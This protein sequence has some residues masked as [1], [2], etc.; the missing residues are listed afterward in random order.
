MAMK[1]LSFVLACL[2]CLSMTAGCE[3]GDKNVREPLEKVKGEDGVPEWVGNPPK[4]CAKGSAES[5]GSMELAAVSAQTRAKKGLASWMETHID[6]MV[7]DFLSG[8]KAEGKTFVDEKTTQSIREVV[9]KTMFGTRM[10]RE[11]E[12]GKRVFS[13]VCLDAES[14][15][16]A[17]EKMNNADEAMRKTLKQRADEEFKDL[18][19]QIEKLKK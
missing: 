15:T 16:G 18:D 17:M 6:G 13:L 4:G 8:G 14:L 5:M 19:R 2:F 12:V 7:K 10:V 9:S 1:K 3:K 11:K